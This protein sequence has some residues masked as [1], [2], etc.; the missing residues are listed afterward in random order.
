MKISVIIPTRNRFDYI[1]LLINDLQNQTVSDFEVIVVDQ[2]NIEKTINNCIYIYTETTGPCVSRNIGVAKAKG[3]ILV[4]L[5]DDARVNPDFIEEI[6]APIIKDRFDAV[7]GA[8]CDLEGNYLLE[9]GDYL[10]RNNL[11][12]IKV[13]T[14]NPNSSESRI[15]LSFPGC[16]ASILTK[17]FH[18]IGGFD[19]TLDPTGAGEDREVA[20]KLYKKG[21]TTWYNSKAKLLHARAPV[22]GSRD[23][24]S[25][26]LMLDVHTYKMCKKH[27]SDELA[28]VL[29]KN[30][31]DVYHKKF[32]GSIFTLKLTRSRYRLLK[33]LK[34][35]M[36]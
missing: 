20:I 29:K 8:M 5:D 15:T 25:R 23:V 11:N 28:D 32:I 24:G 2:S 16:C 4:F 22:G 6:T 26:T 27:F 34:Q 31:I 36:R 3:D 12:F 10:T 1:N 14:S 21:Y 7:A 17:V 9:K 30:I 18:E 35:L 33:E 13:L 19:E